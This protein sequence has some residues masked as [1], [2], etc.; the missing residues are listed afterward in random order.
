MLIKINH[1]LAS[2]SH[3]ARGPDE[4]DEGLTKVAVCFRKAL[5]FASDTSSTIR[6]ENR[7][8][9]WVIDQT[10]QGDDDESASEVR[11]GI[12]LTNL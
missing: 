10:G 1:V 9:T 5:D 12:F 6:K 3:N 2:L 4:M 8:A 11:F 7:T